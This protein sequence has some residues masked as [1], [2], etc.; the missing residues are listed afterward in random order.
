MAHICVTRLYDILC[1]LPESHGAK[2]ATLYG[3]TSALQAGPL[4]VGIRS[5]A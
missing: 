4:C 5:K 1:E 3:K 2:G